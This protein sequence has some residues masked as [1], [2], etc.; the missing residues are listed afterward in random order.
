MLRVCKRLRNRKHSSADTFWD[1]P[2]CADPGNYFQKQAT[3]ANGSYLAVV[4]AAEAPRALVAAAVAAVA[5]QSLS[6]GSSR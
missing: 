3:A 6:Q 2:T 1:T 4:V 5:L